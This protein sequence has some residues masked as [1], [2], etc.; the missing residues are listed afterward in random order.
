MR[1]GSNISRL[2]SKFSTVI[3]LLNSGRHSAWES[4]PD[5]PR[6]DRLRKRRQYQ[7]P[8]FLVGWR[9]YSHATTICALGTDIAH[10]HYFYTAATCKHAVVIQAQDRWQSATGQLPYTSHRTTIA[11]CSFRGVSDQRPNIWTTSQHDTRLHIPSQP[12]VLASERQN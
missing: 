2:W 11:S 9:Q 10:L 7:R 4:V 12:E 8:R 3:V 5:A 1:S 6:A